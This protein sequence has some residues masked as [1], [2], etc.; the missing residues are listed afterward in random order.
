MFT[1][2]AIDA[3]LDEEVRIPYTIG[4]SSGAS[5]GCSY[6]SRQRGRNWEIVERFSANPRYSG[7][8]NFFT[9]R[10]I[11]DLVWVFDQ[12]PNRL[13]PFDFETFYN[14]PERFVTGCSDFYSLKPLYY[15]KEA[16]DASGK[17]V[18]AS[19][20]LPFY[21]PPIYYGGR[22]LVDG[23][24]SD[25]IPLLHSE[26]EGNA[27][28]LVVLTKPKSYRH[29]LK[30]DERALTFYYSFIS[31]NAAGWIK[32]RPHVFNH[33]FKRCLE[34]DGNGKNVSLFIPE[35]LMISRFDRDLDKLKALYEAGYEGVLSRLDEIRDL[36]RV[37]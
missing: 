33:V 2:G 1:A 35:D 8:R 26:A 9:S 21:F 10:A 12:I 6:V 31:E 5:Y 17:L 27:C 19:C 32:I 18:M 36:A 37:N 7:M 28:N 14:T 11:M 3:L 13:V 15:E 24:L 25:P 29:Y 34:E 16:F 23:G 4:V 30:P 20:A 22:R